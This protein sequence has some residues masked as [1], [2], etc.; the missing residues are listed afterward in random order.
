[1]SK[2]IIDRLLNHFNGDLEDGFLNMISIIP[3]CCQNNNLI[4]VMYPKKMRIVKVSVTSLICLIRTVPP[5]RQWCVTVSSLSLLEDEP[6][7][8]NKTD[9][10]P[11]SSPL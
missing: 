7:N 5:I 9:G 10:L 6:A 3:E 11:T 8:N 2:V 1:M 4:I